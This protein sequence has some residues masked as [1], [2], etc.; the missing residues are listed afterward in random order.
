MT[1]KLFVFEGPDGVGKTSVVN[2]L[3]TN[4]ASDQFKFLSFPGKSPGSLGEVIYRIH[5]EPGKLGITKMSAAAK[6]A[7]HIAAH[8]DAI[9]THIRPWIA[10]GTNVVLDRYWWSTL[11]YGR[12]SG[13]NGGVLQK[14][15][16][17]EEAFWD[18]IKPS[19]AFLLDRDEPLERDYEDRSI[20][21]KVREGY[22][23]LAQIESTKYPVIKLRNTGV[24]NATVKVAESAIFEALQHSAKS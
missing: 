13:A 20:W 19:A 18:D 2:E 15:V 16:A 14:L 4:L 22:A 5:H 7:L 1:G 23:I 17:A 21:Q 11:V 3:E 12:T 6:Q 9:D 10:E 8:I 24:L